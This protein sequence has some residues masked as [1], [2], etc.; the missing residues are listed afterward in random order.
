MDDHNYW[1]IIID[2]EEK[3]CSKVVFTIPTYTTRD[4]VWDSIRQQ[5]LEKHHVSC[6]ANEVLWNGDEVTIK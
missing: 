5:S 4:I 2:G 6:Q 1:R 3:I